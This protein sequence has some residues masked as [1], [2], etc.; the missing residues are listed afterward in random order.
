MQY[1]YYFCYSLN[2]LDVKEVLLFVEDMLR[3][4]END[5]SDKYETN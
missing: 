4:L 5:D 2:R 1:S 3:Y